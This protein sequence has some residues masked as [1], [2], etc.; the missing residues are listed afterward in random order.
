MCVAVSCEGFALF[1]LDLESGEVKEERLG[2]LCFGWLCIGFVPN[3]IFLGGD[4]FSEGDLTVIRRRKT[5]KEKAC[6]T[7]VKEKATSLILGADG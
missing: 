4:F 6:C 7:G 2:L 3:R 5:E 1:F